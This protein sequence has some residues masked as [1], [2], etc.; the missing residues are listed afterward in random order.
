MGEGFQELL[1]RTHRQNQ[2]V[3]VEAGE[4]DGFGCG[5]RRDGGKMQTTVIEQQ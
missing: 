1:L 5:G 2:R 4:G 3:K